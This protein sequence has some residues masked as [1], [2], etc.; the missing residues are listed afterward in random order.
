MINEKNCLNGWSYLYE[1][2]IKASILLGAIELEIFF[3]TSPLFLLCCPH[4]F[5]DLNLLNYN[6]DPF[7][8]M[9]SG[10]IRNSWSAAL[11]NSLQYTGRALL[12]LCFLFYNYIFLD[13][14]PTDLLFLFLFM[15]A[16]F[17]TLVEFSIFIFMYV[18]TSLI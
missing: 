9:I 7:Q 14:S 8:L 11:L 4:L 12:S 18:L 2:K 15:F 16:I 5:L 10:K 13:F 3:G 1:Q 17:R 6:F